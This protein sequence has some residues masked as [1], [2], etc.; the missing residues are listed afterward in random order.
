MDDNVMERPDWD[1]FGAVHGDGGDVVAFFKI[2]MTSTLVRGDKAGA[3]EFLDSR[4]RRNWLELRHE[5]D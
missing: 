2:E 5:R 3:F 4:A 1:V